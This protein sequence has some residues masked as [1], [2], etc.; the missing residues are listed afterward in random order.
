MAK[1]INIDNLLLS[2][3]KNAPYL[4]HMVATIT[5][6]LPPADVVKVKHGFWKDEIMYIACSVC[7]AKYS[8]EIVFMNR[9]LEYERPKYCPDCGARMDGDTDDGS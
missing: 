3:K 6:T 8:N 1:Y 9:N 5:F 4:Y 7:G 2:I